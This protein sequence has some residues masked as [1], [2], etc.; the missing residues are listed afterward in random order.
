MDDR[1]GI[2]GGIRITY[3][4]GGS[5]NWARKLMIDLALEGQMSGKLVLYDIDADAAQDNASI[6]N[7]ISAMEEAVGKWSYEVADTLPKALEGSDFVIISILPGTFDEM[8]VDVHAPEKYGIYQSVGDTVGPGG[9]MR[10]LR[11][12]PMYA[13]FA[14]Q[15][16]RYCPEA[17]V[18]NY[19]NPMTLCTRTLYEVFPGIKAFGCCHEVFSAEE[20][21]SALLEVFAGIKSVERT[22]IEINVKGINHFTWIDRASYQSINLMDLYSEAAERYSRDGFIADAEGK[23]SRQRGKWR[24]PKP[25][26]FHMY[27][28]YGLVP[29]AGAR[30]MVEFMPLAWY[31]K[32]HDPKWGFGL[33]TVAERREGQARQLAETKQ[34]VRGETPIRLQQSPEEGVRI[35]KGLVGLGS[36]V[37]NMNLPNQ[38]QIPGIPHGAVVETNAVISLNR[39][40]PVMTGELPVPLQNIALRHV[41]NQETILQ[42]ALLGDYELGF[43]AFLND[44]LV[45]IGEQQ[46]RTLYEEMLQ[47][48]KAYLP[49]LSGKF[50]I[51]GV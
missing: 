48:T 13:E 9:L 24:W 17:W 5:R 27:E 25:V 14:R 51:Q 36:F 28:R 39:V 4:G 12:I 46:A 1:K 20:E 19:T 33:T 45:A 43:Q 8:E 16:E 37:T 3:I 30:H 44:P 29:A 15:I 50:A 41:L 40:Q 10:A 49:G 42:A 23:G 11:T 31:L 38:G 26:H 18:I 7:R 6:G 34:I 22:E 47:G 32:D 2:A 21:L 35:I